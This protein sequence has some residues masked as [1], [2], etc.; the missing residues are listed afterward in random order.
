LKQDDD[1]L[2]G[3]SKILAD[4]KLDAMPSIT[5]LGPEDSQQMLNQMLITWNGRMGNYFNLE[6]LS[7]SELQN[8]VD[9]GD[10]QAAVC[11]LRPDGD[12]PLTLLS[13]FASDSTSN[14]AHLQSEQYD[15]LLEAA[16]SGQNTLNSLVQAETYLNDQGIFYPL[17]YTDRY[18]CANST[19]TGVVVHAADQGIDFIQ[20]GKLE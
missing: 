15:K 8:K 11:A 18:Y 7:E 9:S 19:L 1:V 2:S 4:L 3:L 13:M 17:Y 14:P 5:V 6:T 12:K 20:A 10:Y 16:A